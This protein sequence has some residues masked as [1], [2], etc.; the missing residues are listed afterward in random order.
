MPGGT[1]ITSVWICEDSHG[2]APPN[3]KIDSVDVTV[4]TITNVANFSLSKPNKGW[5]LG[6]YRVDLLI[7][8]KASG[9]AHFVIEAE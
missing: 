3:F 1:K 6:T 9:T 4:G 5:P 2:I 8:G 7:D